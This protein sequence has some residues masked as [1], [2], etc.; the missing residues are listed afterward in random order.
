M[1]E[2]AVSRKRKEREE[3]KEDSSLTALESHGHTRRFKLTK[4]RLDHDEYWE[5]QWRSLTAGEPTRAAR[6]LRYARNVSKTMKEVIEVCRRGNNMVLF[7]RVLMPDYFIPEVSDL[8]RRHNTQDLSGYFFYHPG[9]YHLHRYDKN[10]YCFFHYLDLAPALG[11]EPD[12]ENPL[13]KCCRK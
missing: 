7:E 1:T 10:N 8:V 12:T 6:E 5:S 13:N 2:Q 3:P 4:L 11:L 9:T